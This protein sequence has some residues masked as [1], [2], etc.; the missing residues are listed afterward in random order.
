MTGRVARLVG[1]LSY[2]GNVYRLRVPDVQAAI[3]QAQRD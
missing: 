3:T 1:R 2:A